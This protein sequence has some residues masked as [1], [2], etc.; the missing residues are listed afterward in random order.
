MKG[1][2]SIIDIRGQTAKKWAYQLQWLILSM[3]L[4]ELTPNKAV[5][6]IPRCKVLDF[7]DMEKAC[8][9]DCQG[10][11]PMWATEQFKVGL[12]FEPQGNSCTVILTR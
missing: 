7:P 1:C 11:F 6:N 2:V 5:Y 8:V 9:V 4:V 3:S 12:K 10:A